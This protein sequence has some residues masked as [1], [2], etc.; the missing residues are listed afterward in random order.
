MRRC[1]STV[2]VRMPHA[3]VDRDDVLMVSAQVGVNR[4]CCMI[5]STGASMC[6]RIAAAA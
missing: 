2:N 3:D 4:A 6:W 1:R 5:G